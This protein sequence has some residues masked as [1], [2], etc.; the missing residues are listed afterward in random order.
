MQNIDP[1]FI[2]EPVIVIGF[3]VGTVLYW[4]RKHGFSRAVLGF[5]L[6]AYGGAIGLKVL[7]QYLTAPA[8]L[9]ASQASVWWLGLY[10]GLQTVVFEVG[11]AFLVARFAISRGKMKQSDAVAYGLGLAFWENGVLLGVVA[12]V[13]TVSYFIVLS[14]GGQAAESMYTLL[15]TAQPQLFYSPQSALPLVGWGLLERVSSLM[16]HLSWGYLCVKSV[17]QHKREFLFLA[18]PMGF[19]DFLVPFVQILKLPLFEIIVFMLA[20]I[21]VFVTVYASR[22]REVRHRKKGR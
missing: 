18:L 2:I 5:S 15:S 20:S 9:A 4:Y 21:C 1:L 6:L 22:V 19:I 14:Q 10:I 17:T 16:V 3:S 13:S 11:G 12:L 8:F 7:F